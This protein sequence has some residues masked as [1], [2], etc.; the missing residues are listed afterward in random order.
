LKRRAPATAR[1]VRPIGDVLARVLPAAGLV[2]EIASGT[3]EHAV[4]WAGRFTALEWQPSDPDPDALASVAA[5]RE[6]AGLSNLRAPVRLDASAACWPVER[7]DAVVAVNM[8]HISPWNATL[9]LLAGAGRILPLGAPLVLYG[10]YVK[11]G[12]PLAPSNAAFNR[13]LR[14]RDPAWGLRSVEEVAAAADVFSLDEVVS[15]PANN[16]TLLFRRLA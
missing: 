14:E 8:V 16:L 11:A 7:A 6:E 15:M 2:L 4:A 12:V 13:S 1:N 10:P 5:W 9:G 3:G